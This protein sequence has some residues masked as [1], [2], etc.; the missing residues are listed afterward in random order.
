[1]IAINPDR[2]DILI[3]ALTDLWGASVRTTHHFLTEEDVQKLIPLVT[4]RLSDIETLIVAYDED[5]PTAFM[6]IDGGKIEMLFVAPD[7]FGK[8]IGK[9]LV[10]LGIT[11]YGVRYVDVNEQNPE[12]AGFYCHIGFDVFERTELDEQ[13]NAFPI[14]KMKL[15]SF[16]IRQAR[17]YHA[18]SLIDLYRNTVLTVNRQDYSQAEVEDWASCGEISKCEEMITTHY[19]IVAETLQSQNKT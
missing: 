1:M 18:A 4:M 5:K 11:Q 7:Y 15:R 2:T 3:N 12:A 10:T 16:L 6:G 8:G 17:P 9:T 14:L 19:F 13:G